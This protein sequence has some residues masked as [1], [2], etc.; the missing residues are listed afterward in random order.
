MSSN[1]VRLT[2]DTSGVNLFNVIHLFH[3]YTH[4]ANSSLRGLAAHFHLE[5]DWALASRV[6]RYARRV[7][8]SRAATWICHDVRVRVNAT[9][10]F[11]DTAPQGATGSLRRANHFYYQVD[12]REV[13]ALQDLLLQFYGVPRNTGVY[14]WVLGQVR[15][16][17]RREIVRSVNA[18]TLLNSAVRRDA[19]LWEAERALVTLLVDEGDSLFLPRVDDSIQS[20]KRPRIRYRCTRVAREPIGAGAPGVSIHYNR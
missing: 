9:D 17:V 13:F 19:W 3:S 6:R 2:I 1:Y 16:A 15:F 20:A 8:S 7:R 4:A 14:F 18:P 11:V 10:R 12:H 5:F